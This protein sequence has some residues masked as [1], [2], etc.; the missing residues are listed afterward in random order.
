GSD[1]IDMAK[2][3]SGTKS[4]KWQMNAGQ[5]SNIGDE[6]FYQNSVNSVRKT[7]YVF[8]GYI[9]QSGKCSNYIA[10]TT[11]IPSGLNCPGSLVLAIQ[12]H[13]ANDGATPPIV[14]LADLTAMGH[15]GDEAGNATTGSGWPG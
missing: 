6:L 3:H 4:L 15:V 1:V 5:T 7:E 13:G 9:R 11:A 12:V 14:A 10:G 8:S 2:N